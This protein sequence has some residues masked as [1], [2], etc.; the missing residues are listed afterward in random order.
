MFDDAM[1]AAD[2]G[3]L[4]D[5]MGE[6]IHI[7]PRVRGAANRPAASDISRSSGTVNGLFIQK[8]AEQRLFNLRYLMNAPVADTFE[9][10]VW[11]SA[12]AVVELGFKP[13]KDDL[14]VVRERY[15]A[16][17]STD[18]SDVGDIL[19]NLAIEDRGA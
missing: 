10:H 19:L 6:P 5:V 12:D 4:T 18:E 14:V 7:R 15:F 2:S 17:V 11:L 9:A 8:G 16:V 3:A 1:D 13:D